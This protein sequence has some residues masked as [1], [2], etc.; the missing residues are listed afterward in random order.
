MLL[1][2]VPLV[3]GQHY[4]IKGL[5]PAPRNSTLALEIQVNNFFK[6]IDEH[7]LKP[8]LASGELDIAVFKNIIFFPKHFEEAFL[9]NSIN[10]Y[11]NDFGLD[12]VVNGRYNFNRVLLQD[13]DDENRTR[14][15]AFIGMEWNLL[16]NG[17]KGNTLKAKQLRNEFE[18]KRLERK[19]QQDEQQFAHRELQIN[20][21]FNQLLLNELR[22]H[23][24]LLIEQINLYQELY[25]QNLTPYTEVITL[26]KY[27]EQVKIEMARIDNLNQQSS[28]ANID[29][30]S[31]PIF[32]LKLDKIIELYKGSTTWSDSLAIKHKEY[33]SNVYAQKSMPTLGVYAAHRIFQSQNEN[34]SLHT[35]VLGF[36]FKMPMENAQYRIKRKAARLEKK[37]VDE[38]LKL[39]KEADI[40]QVRQYYTNYQAILKQ[41]KGL[42]YQIY[43]EKEQLQSARISKQQANQG[44]KISS[45][46]HLNNM[47]FMRREMVQKQEQLYLLALKIFSIT[48]TENLS[49]K[50]DI[51]EPINWEEVRLNNGFIILDTSKDLKDIQFF[52]NY[53]KRKNYYKIYLKG[54][55]N[56]IYRLTKELLFLE[57]FQVYTSVN[58]DFR[59][60]NVKGYSSSNALKRSLSEIKSEFVLNDLHSLIQLELN[61]YSKKDPFRN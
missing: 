37:I 26:K 11:K 60:V 39:R 28:Y 46:S 16:N 38:E 29:A 35:P 53:L 13:V 54:E 14:Y 7:R 24:T 22:Y 42:H 23:D 50:S 44:I 5:T 36:S 43:W 41:I 55:Q 32:D 6:N 12:L 45:I 27:Q 30:N 48:G 15:S 57:G 1:M 10:E 52:V 18:M 9:V 25:F 56:N 47:L 59:I 51:I 20:H 40:R 21:I 58:K 34:T 61:N 49:P 19:A 31:F 3:F 33:I 2:F 8:I 17:W 4:D